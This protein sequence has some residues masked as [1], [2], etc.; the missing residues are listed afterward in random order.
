M[1]EEQVNITSDYHGD[2]T[3]ITG[4]PTINGK[5]MG[6]FEKKRFNYW[7]ERNRLF[8]QQIETNGLDVNAKYEV[9]KNEFLQKDASG[10]EYTMTQ[11]HDDYLMGGGKC[12]GGNIGDTVSFELLVHARQDGK[13]QEIRIRKLKMTCRNKQDETTFE[14]LFGGFDYD[15]SLDDFFADFMENP[16]YLLKKR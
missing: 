7:K 13:E 6:I 14:M 1:K 4:T 2:F 9:E 16:S 11:S 3:E 15:N 5:R 8:M 12:Y 10:N